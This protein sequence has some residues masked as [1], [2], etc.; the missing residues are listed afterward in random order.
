MK[1][2]YLVYAQEKR[3]EIFLN[4]FSDKN[5]ADRYAVAYQKS[6]PKCQSGD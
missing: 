4:S 5:A 1:I 2:Q 6:H 3:N